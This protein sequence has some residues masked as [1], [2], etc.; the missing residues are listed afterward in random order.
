KFGCYFKG[1]SVS[2]I[3]YADDLVLLSPSICELQNMLNVFCNELALLDLQV[4]VKK[5]SAIRIGNRYKSKCTDL[6]LKDTK[7]PWTTEI[8][9]LGIYIVAATKFKC[10]FD[11]AKAKYYRSANAILDKLGNNNNKP[12]TLKLISTI[13]VPCLTYS[14]EAI[15]LTKTELISL[16]SPWTRAFEK[17]FKNF[18]KN[19]IKQCQQYT[20]FMPMLPMYALKVMYFLE[21]LNSTDN[22]MLKTLS[23][24]LSMDDIGRL[25]LLFNSTFADFMSNYRTIIRLISK[26]CKLQ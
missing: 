22:I 1:I 14:L 24:N 19:I 8:K 3:M 11:A 18:D 7:I 2:A 25:A 9:Y 17:I 21:K 12:V 10:N 20:G 26:K 5:C 23:N 13:A 4:N 15:S 16:N 6:I